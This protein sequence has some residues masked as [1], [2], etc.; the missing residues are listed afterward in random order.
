M[1]RFCQSCAIGLQYNFGLV[2]VYV[3][4]AHDQDDTRERS[5]TWNGLE[6][7]IIHVEK[8]HLWFSCFENEVSQFLNLHDC[9]ERQHQLRTL[10]SKHQTLARNDQTLMTMFGKSSKCTSNGSNM[11]FR[12]Q[13]IW[14]GCSST[15][16]ERI[17]AATSSAV[18]H[19]AS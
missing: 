8:R 5:V 10:K 4:P 17:R 12:V 16:N 13:I 9:L 11:A 15:G 3:E 14:R 7:V 19:L 2:R 1:M 18:F 6:P